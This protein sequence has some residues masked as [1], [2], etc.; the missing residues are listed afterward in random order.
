MGAKFDV[1]HINLVGYLTDET[2]AAAPRSDLQTIGTFLMSLAYGGNLVSSTQGSP[3]DWTE[4]VS[5]AARE[6]FRSLNF[7]F[8][9]PKNAIPVDSRRYLDP[10]R[11]HFTGYDF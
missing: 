10:L 3:E 6:Q 4:R 9:D 2:G 8:D 1:S 11:T 7:Q 5:R